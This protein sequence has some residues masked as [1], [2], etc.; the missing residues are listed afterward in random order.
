MKFPVTSTTELALLDGDVHIHILKIEFSDHLIISLSE[1]G[2]L[3]DLVLSIKQHD[4]AS[5]TGNPMIVRS[6]DT[7]TILGVEKM[8][9]HLLTRQIEQA[10]NTEKT[11][12]VSTN[13]R[14]DVSF[15]DAQLICERL[16]EM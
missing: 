3:G 11:I 15:K 14:K 8:N 16:T 4:P 1:N 10:L 13:L 9:S 7:R 12:L 5:L 2:K 6:V